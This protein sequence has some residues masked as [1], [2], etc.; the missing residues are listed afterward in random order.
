MTIYEELLR[1]LTL[2]NWG[3]DIFLGIIG[4]A[5]VVSLVTDT[6]KFIKDVKRIRNGK[7][8][9]SKEIKKD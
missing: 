6:I 1:Q 7:K 2:L 3:L 8:S 5:I 4:L 9:Q